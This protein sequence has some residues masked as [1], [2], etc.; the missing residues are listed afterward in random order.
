MY[1]VWFIFKSFC[2]VQ[3]TLSIPVIASL[4]GSS[5]LVSYLFLVLCKHYIKRD[6]MYDCS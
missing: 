5:L 4:S 6:C 2:I 3:V 1:N